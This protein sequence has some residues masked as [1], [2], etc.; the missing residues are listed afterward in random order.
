MSWD[1]SFEDFYLATK[2]RCLQ[3]VIEVTTVHLTRH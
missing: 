1:D 3:A 2:D